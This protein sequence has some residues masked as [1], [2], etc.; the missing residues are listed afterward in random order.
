[1]IK[2]F[3]ISINRFQPENAIKAIK[4]GLID[5][6]E[7]VYNIFEQAPEDKLF[8][9]CREMGVAVIA[10]V[11]FDEGALT[12]SLTLETKYPENDW[13]STYFTPEVL[14][15]NVQHTNKLKKD[16]PENITMPE[17]ALRFILS[18][19]D[20]STTIPGMRKEKNVIAN[21]SSSEKGKLDQDLIQK[22]RGH[23]WDRLSAV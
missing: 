16:L 23:R 2:A 10:R 21:V 14:K 1:M 17:L 20:V 5:A 18:N 9:L 3:G 22:L 7:V 6:V 8:P 15:T 13:R 19:S 4:T 11:P 12:G